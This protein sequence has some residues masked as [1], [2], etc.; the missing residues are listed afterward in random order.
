[1]NKLQKTF[2]GSHQNTNHWCT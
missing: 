2:T 1:V